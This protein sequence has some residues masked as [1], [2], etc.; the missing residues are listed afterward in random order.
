VHAGKHHTLFVTEVCPV[1]S[2]NDA[3]EE[4][5]ALAHLKVQRLDVA[6]CYIDDEV[7]LI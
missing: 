2:V 4:A 6:G 5:Q 7:G 3:S 1:D